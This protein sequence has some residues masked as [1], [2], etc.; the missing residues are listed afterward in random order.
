[1]AEEFIKLYPHVGINKRQ[2]ADVIRRS[3]QVASLTDATSG[4]RIHERFGEFQQ[5]RGGLVFV[6]SAHFRRHY[7]GGPYFVVL[8]TDA[9]SKATYVEAV[10]RLTGASVARAFEKIILRFYQGPIKLVLSDLGSEYISVQ[11]QALCGSYGIQHK[12]TTSSFANKS[13]SAER[14]IRELRRVLARL[15]SSGAGRN[16]VQLL[17]EAENYFNQVLRNSITGL[18]AQQTTND[19]A[20]IVLEKLLSHRAKIAARQPKQKLMRIGDRVLLRLPLGV[21]DK[22]DDPKFGT[23]IYTI[24]GVKRTSPRLSYRLRDEEGDTVVGSFPATSLALVEDTPALQRQ[25]L[26]AD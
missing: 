3:K 21:F 14:R 15:R 23:Q 25:E 18:T 12:T 22:T 13:W 11:F 1:M 26:P 4:K 9:Y 7:L 19:K 20:P 16:L 17:K 10:K 24:V 2:I 8:A 6:D 5:K